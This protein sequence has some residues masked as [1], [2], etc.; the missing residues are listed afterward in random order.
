[1]LLDPIQARAVYDLAA[2]EH[3]AVL[4]VNADSP[5]C[6]IDVLE[7]ARLSSS[8]VI[9]ETSLW[10]LKGHSFGAG[11]PVRG[12]TRYLADISIVTEDPAY[13]GIP[14]IFHTDHIKGPDTVRI[15]SSW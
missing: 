13:A 8:P 7:A 15:S 3:F 4:A 5:A 1:M 11:D 10:Q 12:L 14:V 6:V 9:V 2:R